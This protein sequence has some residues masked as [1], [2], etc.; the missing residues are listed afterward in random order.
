M[1]KST[2][3]SIFSRP[4]T[5]SLKLFLSSLR[6]QRILLTILLAGIVL[7][8]WYIHWGL[9][10]L[11]EEATP[12]VKSWNMWNWGKPGFELNPHFFNY[13]ALTFYL[14][15]LLQG[16]QFFLGFLLGIYRNLASYGASMTSI[17][18]P[19]RLLSVAFDAGTIWVTAQFIREQFDERTSLVTAA[20]LALS[21]LLIEQAHYITVD[22]P[23]TF[24]TALSLLYIFRVFR[25]GNRISYLLAGV[26]VG[27]A[28]STKYTGA[29]LIPVFV[30]AHLMRKASASKAVRGLR[31]PN[32]WYGLSL[33]GIVFFAAN[34]FILSSYD[35]FIRDFSFE[36][37]HVA[38]GHLG[39]TP[40]QSTL[41]YYSLEVLPGMLGWPLF[42]LIVAS[43]ATTFVQREKPLLLLLIFP[44]IYFV[45]ISSW[46][47]RA[48]RYALPMIPMLLSIGALALVRCE[49]ILLRSVSKGGPLRKFSD[50]GLAMA[51]SIFLAL[52]M[53][54]GPLGTIYG[55]ERT[56]MTKD[57]RTIAREWLQRK[58]KTGATI[59]T[60]PY[61]IVIPDSAY[62]VLYIPFLAEE[63]ERVAAFYD[64]RWYEDCDLLVASDFDEAR[65]RL[66]PAKYGGMLPYYDTLR[67]RWQQ[68]VEITP[69][70][71][72]PGPSFRFY[73]P[74]M[75]T[76]EA[77]FDSTLFTR[78]E[79]VPESARVSNFLRDLAVLLIQKG[80][81][82][83][84][85]QVLKNIISVEPDNLEARFTLA[86]VRLT[87]G[88][89]EAALA[90]IQQLA[91]RDPSRPEVFVFAG[92][93]LMNL[94]RGEEAENSLWKA[95]KIDDR[96]PAAYE[97]LIDYYTR[98]KM[99]PKLLQT[100]KQYRMILPQGSALEKD[101]A[102]RIRE[103]EMP[104]GKQGLK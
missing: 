35:E 97:D 15:F 99:N 50:Q 101:V 10:D 74:P 98:N 78:L 18:I 86:R 24:F 36:Q 31:Q 102:E 52:V 84:A 70:S 56:F 27:L 8:L 33:S 14:N 54:A 45:M 44:L 75:P 59:A 96:Y 28:A 65:Y 77:L 13:P 19:S 100:L 37:F 72:Q 17:V 63:S 62:H 43:I 46:E 64:T 47:M 67:A 3:T 79:S 25:S 55:K 4:G 41:G 92:D 21:P 93:V 68:L 12:L 38:Y 69:Q 34:P 66:E 91:F 103:L 81:L 39:L 53:L 40:G 32:L 23:L 22:T 48:E 1:T 76:G 80:K 11:Y 89:N 104:K 87:L 20:L 73:A 85:G 26:S 95:L 9:P 57:T 51:V 42:A 90:E 6:E 7:R 94:G 71:Y 60:G 16:L 2:S 30:A 82:H 29:A 88:D 58:V 61:G 49:Q 83:K 5:F